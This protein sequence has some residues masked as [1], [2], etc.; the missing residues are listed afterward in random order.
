MNLRKTIEAQNP[1]W[2]SNYDLNL[3][4][5]RIIDRQIRGQIRLDTP[6]I[7]VITGVRRSGKSTLFRLFMHDLIEQGISARS[8]VSLN[9][10]YPAFIPYYNHPEELDDII[11]QAEMRTKQRCRYLFL[12]EIQNILYWEKWVKAVY[13]SE[14]F[15]KIFITGSNADLLDGSYATRLSGRYHRYENMPFSFQEYLDLSSVDVGKDPIDRHDQQSLLSAYAE[16]YLQSGGF[17][18]V[19]I[20]ND[21]RLLEIYYQ[22]IVLK[23]VIDHQVVRHPMQ[24]KALT[25]YLMS[26]VTHIYSYHRLGK[27]F[28]LHEQTVKEY[29]G[30]LQSAYLFFDLP[31][32]HPSVSVQQRS[33]KKLYTIDNGLMHEIG[34]SFSENRGQY[35]ENLVFLELHRRGGELFYHRDQHEC[36]FLVKKGLHITQAIQVCVELH[37]RNKKRELN[38]LKEAL[39]AYGLTEGYIVTL[40]QQD[41]YKEKGKKIH[42]IPLWEWLLMDCI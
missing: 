14:R 31:K 30:Y 35:L 16:Q 39:D 24:L 41:V 29:M 19:L 36:D 8:I 34:F 1:H 15:E 27:K 2:K 11:T 4:K 10:D 33:R 5:K 38:G 37:D 12:D 7:E 42:I 3:G 26:N 17:P 20:Q 23:D 25:Y 6:T 21:T 18:A 32:Y 13:D 9:F 22:T 40:N 28:D